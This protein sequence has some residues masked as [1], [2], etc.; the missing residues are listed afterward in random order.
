MSNPTKPLVHIQETEFEL[1]INLDS[2]NYLARMGTSVYIH[3]KGE[4]EKLAL[5]GPAGDAAWRIFRN[6]SVTIY[7]APPAEVIEPNTS[8][9]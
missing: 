9:D 3:F 1:V 8:N 4:A 2:V 7:Q 6:S 5:R